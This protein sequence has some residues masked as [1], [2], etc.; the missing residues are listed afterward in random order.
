MR[1]LERALG[2]LNA[3]DAPEDVMRR[4]AEVILA[5]VASLSVAV[6]IANNRA[7][8][9]DA[10]AAATI[11]TGYTRSEL[12]RMTVWDLTPTPRRNLGLRLWRDFIRRGRM[13]GNYQIRRKDGVLVTARYV[14]LAHV[15]PGLHVSALTTAALIAELTSG[16]LSGP[17]RS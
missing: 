10:N 6:L 15:L 5:Q 2:R 13:R 9:V 16:A 12:L 11:L 8:Y 4:R 14:A 3:K 1:A 17:P 7:R